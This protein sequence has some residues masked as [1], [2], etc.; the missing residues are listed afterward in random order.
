MN[1]KPEIVGGDLSVVVAFAVIEK[2]V[3][4]IFLITFLDFF[5]F[6]CL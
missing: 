1:T 5:S 4:S 6:F 2:K 3:I